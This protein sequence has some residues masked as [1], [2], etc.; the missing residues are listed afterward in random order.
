MWM[1]M[2]ER[3]R[4]D[5]WM[6]MRML[7]IV[8]VSVAV[9]I[10]VLICVPSLIRWITQ[11]PVHHTCFPMRV[12]ISLF[13]CRRIGDRYT[14]RIGTAASYAHSSTSICLTLSSSPEIRMRFALPQAQ[15]LP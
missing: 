8:P 6:A 1:L 13:A 5:V 3:V 10:G 15:V 7:V 2:I 9:R 11:W 4:V 12:F 14:V